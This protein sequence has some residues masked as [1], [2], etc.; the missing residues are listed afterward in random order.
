MAASLILWAIL[1][2]YPVVWLAW[3]SLKPSAEIQSYA[4]APPTSIYLENYSL[5]VFSERG[6][7]LGI[8][9]H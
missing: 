8:Y 3:S 4:F 6:I 1:P 5:G 7:T 2:L 9:R